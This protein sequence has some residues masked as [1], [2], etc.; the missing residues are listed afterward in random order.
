MAQ[1]SLGTVT[2]TNGSPTVVAD[3]DAN[4]SNVL[5]GEI[6]ALINSNIWYEVAVV[7]FTGGFW[8]I[9]LSSNYA[10][11]TGSGKSYALHS[12]FTPVLSL[13]Y[14]ESGDTMTASIIKRAFLLI[15]DYV[16]DGAIK[17][18]TR[19]SFAVVNNSTTGDAFG[20][21]QVS[22]AQT[23]DFAALRLFTSSQNTAYIS[24]GKYTSATAFTEFMRLA[25]DGTVTFSGAVSFT[26]LTGLTS[27]TANAPSTLTL[28]GGTSGGQ[29]VL[30]QG[31]NASVSLTAQGSGSVDSTKSFR[32]TGVSTPSS[33]SSIELNYGG[34]ASTGSIFA[35]NRT[36]GAYLALNIDGL[37]LSFNTVSG[38]DITLG[39]AAS[40]VILSGTAAG[41]SSANTAAR[42]AG[43]FGV[44]GASWFD[45]VAKFTS[46]TSSSSPSNGAVVITG[47]LGVGGNVYSNGFVSARRYEVQM[48]SVSYAAS[49]VV[50]MSAEGLGTLD[51]AGDVT[52]STSNRSAGRMRVLKITS[53]ASSRLLSFPAW[54]FV[55]A[56]PTSI[57]ANKTA[58]LVL[59]CYGANETD[60][61]AVYGAED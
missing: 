3:V 39:T 2:V 25:N 24:F 60:V 31:A 45:G 36:G 20:I 16:T 5:P 56:K 32:V 33:G 51:L 50:D 48:A 18:D 53:G 19:R 7:A 42:V 37:S 52:F 55:S 49:T 46:A 17:A 43:S 12:S 8:Q 6:F 28:N 58:N 1:Y 14:P 44:A 27:I 47:G 11:T 54:V 41:S 22:A 34:V 23:G 30:G 9:T 13:P 35:Y 29:I 40:T 26:A 10:G 59:T 4:W 61:L 15:E 57:A 38:G 21:E